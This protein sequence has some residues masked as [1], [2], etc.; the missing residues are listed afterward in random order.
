MAYHHAPTA[1]PKVPKRSIGSG[2]LI[3]RYT[4]EDLPGRRLTV[5]EHLFSRCVSG[6]PW[7]RCF[8]R[9]NAAREM[10]GSYSHADILCAGYS[11]VL[12]YAIHCSAS[13]TQFSVEP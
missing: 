3:A 6:V 2:A 13:E 1:T 12:C 10:A 4:G 9:S 8:R 7:L 5:F 11:W